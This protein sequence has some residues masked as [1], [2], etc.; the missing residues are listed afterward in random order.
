MNLPF[1][2][3]AA[4]SCRGGGGRAPH[5]DPFTVFSF[6]PAGIVPIPLPAEALRHVSI[7]RGKPISPPLT[8]PPHRP[9]S[10]SPQELRD[11]ITR[12]AEQMLQ[13]EEAEARSRL[14]LHQRVVALAKLVETMSIKVCVCGGGDGWGMD[15]PA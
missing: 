9:P 5:E 13:R 6:S 8:P 11:V 1:L 4:N 3:D 10:P 15:H 14:T 12:Q 2:C 7:S